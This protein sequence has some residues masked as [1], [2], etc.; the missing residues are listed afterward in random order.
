MKEIREIL[1]AQARL[2]GE[3]ALS[4]E[5]PDPSATPELGGLRSL[6]AVLASAPVDSEHPMSAEA[7]LEDWRTRLAREEVWES[8]ALALQARMDGE[9]DCVSFVATGEVP[10]KE[11]RLAPALD[12]LSQA[13][14]RGELE[15][16][17]SGSDDFYWHQ[18]A[19][20]IE[21][22][23]VVAESPRSPQPFWSFLRAPWLASALSAVITL[24]IGARM[25]AVAPSSEPGAMEVIYV[26]K[27]DS[28][29]MAAVYWIDDPEFTDFIE[30]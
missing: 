12:R 19:S 2:D 7:T 24:G 13:L 11:E 10:E 6:K 1:D 21:A 3:A 29:E 26:A 30:D 28:A 15:T 25:A 23:D 9:E 27:A 4:G 16:S 17:P 20:A 5:T 8:N 18:I 14:R 22:E